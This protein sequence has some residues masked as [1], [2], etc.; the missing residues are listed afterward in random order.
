MI[1]NLEIKVCNQFT[2]IVTSKHS[3][4]FDF[5]NGCI[6]NR[7][8][9]TLSRECSSNL[10]EQISNYEFFKKSLNLNNQLSQDDS[11]FYKWTRNIL[12]LAS[13]SIFSC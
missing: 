3:Y 7:L 10:K 12:F 2:S 13:I 11:I 5:Q 1:S 6:N 4:K 8:L 9:H